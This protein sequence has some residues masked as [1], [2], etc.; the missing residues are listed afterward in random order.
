MKIP[1]ARK[2][3][4]GRWFIQMRLGGESVS[5][6][7]YSKR[8]CEQEATYIKAEYLAGRRVQAPAEE[9]PVVTLDAAI[10]EYCGLKSN[11]LSP[12]TLRGYQYIRKNRLKSI[13]QKDVYELAELPK[14]EWQ[15]IVNK[16]AGAVSPKTLKNAVLFVRTVIKE[17]TGAIIPE[18]TLPAPIGQETAFLTADEIPK[19]VAAV[20][21]TKVAVPALLALSSM[22]L[23]EIQALDWIDI[24]RNPDFIRTNGAVVQGESQGFIR[25]KQNKN[26]SSARDV[27]ILIPE[28][29]SA[30]ERDRKPEGPVM[31]FSRTYF[32]RVIHGI[33]KSE[34]I[35]DITI[36]GL[37]HSFASL[38]YHLQMP[39]KIAMEIGGWAD[40]GTMHKI[41]THI[42]QK[43]ITR[44][45]TAIADFYSG[46]ISETR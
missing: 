24:K 3:S 36:H 45:K 44:Y 8:K 38:A 2:L 27:P 19:F 42:A 23:S 13:M 30:I 29:K 41:Y 28:L 1:Q 16:E 12:A 14:K 25:K 26:I 20:Y 35:T 32:R 43:D 21:E 37:R 7:D 18:V 17:K 4:S 34:N 9:R 22:R 11:V 40:P 39:E 46:N 33:C 5:V 31:D 15:K 10:E 6:S